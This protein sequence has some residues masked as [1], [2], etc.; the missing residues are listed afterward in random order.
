VKGRS[1]GACSNHIC[2]GRPVVAYD[3]WQSVRITGAIVREDRNIMDKLSDVWVLLRPRTNSSGGFAPVGEWSIQFP[4]SDGTKCCAVVSGQCWLLVENIPDPVR[5]RKDD[6]ILLP[7]NR[8]VRVASDLKFTPVE[9]KNLSVT[10]SQRPTRAGG[11]P[12]GAKM[13][14]GAG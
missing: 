14:R 4:R 13:G 12:P 10:P 8:S 9:V 2:Y 3:L 1:V 6:Y 7:A 11:G 5:M